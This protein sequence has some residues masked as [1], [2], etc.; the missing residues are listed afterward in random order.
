M[1]NIR[2]IALFSLLCLLVLIPTA[3]AMD[4]QTDCDMD[5]QTALQASD[6]DSVMGVDCYF[7]A[8]IDNDNGNGS[9]DNPY[10]NIT[11]S[12]VKD[13]S[14]NYLNDGEYRLTGQVN[15]KNV[16]IIGQD[17]QKTILYFNGIGFNVLD[18]LTLQNLTLV[19]LA[20]SSN[21][22]SVIN[23][24]NVLF[25]NWKMLPFWVVM[26]NPEVQYISNRA[27]W[28]LQTHCLSITMQRCMAEQ[29]MLESPD[30]MLEI[31]L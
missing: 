16:T 2:L 30:S 12:R 27:L 26:R 19:N 14:V 6:E 29:Y 28:R 4:N 10:R 25:K 20:I 18:S 1:K 15:K 11:P 31:W 23:A 9:S 21:S 8:N 5:N 13:N 7:D 24:T 17:P 22:N 3:Y